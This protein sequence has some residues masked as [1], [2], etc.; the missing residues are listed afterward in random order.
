MD[1]PEYVVK[2]WPTFG[3]LFYSNRLSLSSARSTTF[4]ER[5][6]VC[7]CSIASDYEA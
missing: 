5:R 2:F 1:C 4:N 6:S 3:Q 7:S